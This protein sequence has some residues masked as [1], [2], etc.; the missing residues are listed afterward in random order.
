MNIYDRFC[1]PKGF[2]VY[3]YLREDGT[4][5][6]IG[7]GRHT[8]ASEKHSVNKP[9][10]H[11]RIIIIEQHLTELGAHAIERRLIR[12]YGRKDN[13]TGILRNRT[14]GGEGSIGRKDSEEVRRKRGAANLGRK[15]TDEA[16][17]KMSAWDRTPELRE[18]LS[19]AASGRT[20]WNKGVTGQI[21][22]PKT[23]AS[24]SFILK[25]K[26]PLTC[27]H[28]GKIGKGNVM[29]RYHFTNCKLNA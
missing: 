19:K 10:D 12:W 14:D 13:N 27:P 18:K 17:E 9:I 8:R 20:P 6:Y 4:P 22:L 29:H 11:Q 3:A 26:P 21:Q 5:Y 23:N 28:C 1:P 16:R 24:R 2:Y 7:K 15:H 25:N